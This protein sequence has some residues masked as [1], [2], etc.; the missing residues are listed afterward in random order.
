[1]PRGDG[2][3]K[4]ARSRPVHSLAR[5]VQHGSR[6]ETSRRLPGDRSCLTRARRASRR[7]TS[8][9]VRRSR[10]SRSLFRLRC[11][12]FAARAAPCDWTP[13]RDAARDFFLSHCHHL[14][15]Y[16]VAAACQQSVSDL[17]RNQSRQS[18]RS[19]R[20]VWFSPRATPWGRDSHREWRRAISSGGESGNALKGVAQS[21][22]EAFVRL[23]RPRLS[24][25]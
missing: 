7:T 12:H 17:Q 21:V 18:L 14:E 2:P 13:L 8:A 6:R 20:P 16:A 3:R 1:M 15:P 22:Q 23:I 5:S 9:T 10:E 11:F 24:G 4:I 19:P 25:A